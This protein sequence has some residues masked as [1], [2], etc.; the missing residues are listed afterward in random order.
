VA[1]LSEQLADLSARAKSVEDAAAAAQEEA[2]DKIM[3]R[4]DQARAAVTSAVEK[5]NQHV[6]SAG[7]NAARD[8]GCTKSKN[9]RRHGR[10]EGESCRG[11]SAQ[12]GRGGAALSRPDLNGLQRLFRGFACQRFEIAL[13]QGLLLEQLLCRPV[14]YRTAG[15]QDALRAFE[16]RSTIARTS[17]S[18]AAA[19]SSAYSRSRT[20][21]GR[22]APARKLPGSRS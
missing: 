12:G 1:K 9:R 14:Q 11:R 21:Y 3:T 13:L 20:G 8:W 2:R 7:D 17:S 5:V 4:R 15:L 10:S 18:T 19:V 6:T 16:T 22:S